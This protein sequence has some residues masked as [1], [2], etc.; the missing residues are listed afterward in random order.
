MTKLSA[1]KLAPPRR[2]VLYLVPS[3]GV[4][5]SGVGPTISWRA[6]AQSDFPS[7]QAYEADRASWGGHTPSKAES[8]AKRLALKDLTSVQYSTDK[9][10]SNCYFIRLVFEGARIFDCE[11]ATKE[12]FEYLMD[13]FENICKLRKN[14]SDAQ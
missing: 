3:S 14:L 13:G 10:K 8:D 4:A 2:R 1:N 9:I 7:P 11:V 6:P 5:A 12:D